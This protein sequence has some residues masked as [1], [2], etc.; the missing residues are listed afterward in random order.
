MLAAQAIAELAHLQARALVK[1]DLQ[2]LQVAQ[3]GHDWQIP[4]WMRPG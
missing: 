2:H 1:T 3:S 4:M